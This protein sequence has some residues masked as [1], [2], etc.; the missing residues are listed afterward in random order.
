MTNGMRQPHSAMSSWSSS[1]LRIAPCNVAATVPVVT[2]T[3]RLLDQSPRRAG[4]A[5]SA[6]NV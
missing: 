5:A 4:G 1:P 2:A 6:R 3:Y